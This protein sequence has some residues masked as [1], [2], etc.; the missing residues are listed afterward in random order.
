MVSD[1]I[2]E[3]ADSFSFPI[4]EER[5]TAVQMRH[6]SGMVGTP[7]KD[8]LFMTILLVGA[9]EEASAIPASTAWWNSLLG[10]AEQQKLKLV[11][12]QLKNAY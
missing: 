8:A 12:D 9:T 10:I 11:E 1:R 6:D 2:Y 3:H 7:P 4:V 5:K